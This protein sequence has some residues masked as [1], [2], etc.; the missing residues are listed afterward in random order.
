LLTLGFASPVC[1]DGGLHGTKLGN[2]ALKSVR[3]GLCKNKIVAARL[4]YC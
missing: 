3:I 1:K 2:K 4:R